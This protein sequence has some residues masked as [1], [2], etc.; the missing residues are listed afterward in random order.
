MHFHLH[1]APDIADPM[2][3]SNTRSQDLPKWQAEVQMPRATSKHVGTH[4]VP[5]GT[6]AMPKFNQAGHIT[7]QGQLLLS[8]NPHFEKHL[9]KLPWR[10]KS[11]L[12]DLSGLEKN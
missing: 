6:W 8:A 12:P 2:K 10:E 5:T 4:V 3:T 9:Q 1:K 11:Q 7:L